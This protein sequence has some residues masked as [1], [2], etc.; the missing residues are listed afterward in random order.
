MSSVRLHVNEAW[1]KAL[2]SDFPP[3]NFSADIV[4]SK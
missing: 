4:Y 2:L 1:E 3:N